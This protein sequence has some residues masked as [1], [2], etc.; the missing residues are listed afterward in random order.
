MKRLEVYFDFLCPYCYEGHKNLM[1]LLEHHSDLEIVWKPCEAN[2][3]PE[4]ASIHSDLATAGF[5]YLE[6]IGGNTD[7]YVELLYSNYFDHGQRIDDVFV[8]SRLAEMCGAEAD[9]FEAAVVSE[10]YAARVRAANEYAWNIL[11]WSAVPSYVCGGKG[12]GSEPGELVT[13][14]QLDAFISEA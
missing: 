5:F 1:N 2:P 12:I 13:A 8:L 10:E 11:G 9:E 14:E 3:R 7:I 6:D 4:V